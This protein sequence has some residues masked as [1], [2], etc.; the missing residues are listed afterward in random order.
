MAVVA[1][2]H[3]HTHTTSAAMRTLT[4]DE[5]SRAFLTATAAST[6]EATPEPDR[7]RQL[8]KG[9]ERAEGDGHCTNTPSR[10]ACSKNRD[11]RTGHGSPFETG[12]A[13]PCA[14][15]ADRGPHCLRSDGL[16]ARGATLNWAYPNR[17]IRYPAPAA[18]S[19]QCPMLSR[20]LPFSCS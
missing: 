3:R 16:A 10:C 11:A 13:D 14:A 20:S 17:T 2:R 5:R 12:V 6:A 4:P 9:F 19:G 1:R 15:A 8:A 18:K 7:H